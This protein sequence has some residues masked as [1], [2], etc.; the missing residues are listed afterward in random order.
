MIDAGAGAK[1]QLLSQSA[2]RRRH[3]SPIACIKEIRFDRRFDGCFRGTTSVVP[4]YSSKKRPGF[5]R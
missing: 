5:S 3:A 2:R 1:G 4:K